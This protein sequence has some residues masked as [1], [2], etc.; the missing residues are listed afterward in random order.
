MSDRVSPHKVLIVDDHPLI[1]E[2]LTMRL[3]RHADL[4]V[5]GEAATAQEA[6][7]LIGLTA[8][9]LVLV[10]ISLKDGNGLELVKQIQSRFSQ[11][12]ML[13]LSAYDE[14]VYAERA[15]RAGA[16]GYLN[17][18]ESN[19]KLLEA[20]RTVLSGQRF[21]S[22]V[23]AQRLLGQALSNSDP[24]KSPIERLTNRELEIFR[25]IGAGTST[26]NIASRLFLSPNTIDTHRENIKRKL[27]LSNASELT[28]YAV[29]WSLE[30]G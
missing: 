28:R 10:D 6:I 14:S 21:L 5:C 18:Q 30:N 19:E 27:N 2:G 29:Q 1:R 3:S 15:L 8:P 26:G 22:A 11:V 25:L 23:M 20:I 17:K 16:H 9:N 24:N 13:V 12:K 4:A 7:Q